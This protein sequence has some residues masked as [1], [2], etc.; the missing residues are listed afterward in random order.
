MSPAQPSSYELRRI[1]AANLHPI[2]VDLDRHFW[3]QALQELL[4]GN[5]AVWTAFEL[6][7]MVVVPE[8]GPVL[9]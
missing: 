4:V 1:E 9:V 3:A 2:R 7:P 8:F 6:P 5:L